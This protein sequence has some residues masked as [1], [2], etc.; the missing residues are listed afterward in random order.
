[1]RK[2]TEFP[3]FPVVFPPLGA[4]SARSPPAR[5]RRPRHQP[6]PRTGPGAAI[7]RIS[8]ISD[9]FPDPLANFREPGRCAPCTDP[10]FIENLPLAVNHSFGGSMR[11][12]ESV[13]AKR[14]AAG[15]ARGRG[16]PRRADQR[17]CGNSPEFPEFRRF[18]GH[19]L[20]SRRGFDC[21]APAAPPTP[22]HAGAPAAPPTPAHRPTRYESFSNYRG[23]RTLGTN[24]RPPADAS[25]CVTFAPCVRFAQA[26]APPC[27]FALHSV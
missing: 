11:P 17:A 10:V 8:G 18:S 25:P 15:R 24:F 27:L 20:G 4:R 21:R 16:C 26:V 5:A 7:S 13:P 9:D 22:T 6:R 3:K 19:S 12:W 1:M 2:F 23:F 14:G